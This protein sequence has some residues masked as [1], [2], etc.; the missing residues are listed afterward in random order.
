MRRP[1][2][3]RAIAYDLIGRHAANCGRPVGI[4]RLAVAA[5]EEIGLEN[6]VADAVSVEESAVVPPLGHQRVRDAEHQRDI[7]SR[8]DRVPDR[9]G[10][11]RQIVA[12]RS[13]QMKFGAAAAGGAQPGQRDVLAG[14]AAADIVVL[15]RH[16]AK[17]QHERAVRDQL[18]PADVVAG[19][20]L[21]RTDDVRQDHRRRARAVAAHRAD[22]AAGHIQKPVEL[23]WRVVEA[24]C[25]RPAIRAAED[26]A[27]AMSRVNALQFRPDEIERARPL[28]GDELVAAAAAIGAGAAFEPATPDHRPGDPRAVRYRGGNVAEQRR[29]RGIARMRH[30]LDAIAALQHGEGTPMGAVREDAG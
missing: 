13:D 11:G 27:R 26:G 5:A 15:Q 24:P 29:R 2:A 1:A 18:V 8:T 30:H 3:C 19:D 23:A 22:I 21:L 14:P 25:A 17:R 6:V 4:L 16:A 20:G 9:L 12:Q 10:L 28:D 7:R